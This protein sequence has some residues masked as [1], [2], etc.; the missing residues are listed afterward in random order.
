MLPFRPTDSDG[1]LEVL[2][3]GSHADDIEIGCGGTLLRLESLERELLVRWVVLGCAD[4]RRASE[5]ET[6]AC[7]FFAGAAQ[8]DIRL[9]RF[10]D[11]FMPYSGGDVKRFF[12]QLKADFAPQLIFTH[13]RHDLHQDHR[14]ACELTWNS[15]R[16]HLI[17]EYEVPKYDGDF[18]APNVFVQLDSTT[19]E[20]K[21]AHI[22]EHFPSQAGKHWF[23]ADL[24][25]S[26]HRLRG[27]ESHSPTGL[28][29][30]FY[31]RKLVLF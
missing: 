2:A 1:P 12:E 13:Y 18:G 6:S 4:D 30:A 19:S 10:P 8:L 29:E 31:G 27:M 25:H 28:A 26:L 21:I 17:L 15:F 23:T 7:A 5:A 22:L 11:A 24:F 16:D 20:R 9:G 14:L 3:I